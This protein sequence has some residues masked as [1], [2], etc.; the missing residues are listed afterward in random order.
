MCGITGII[1]KEKITPAESAVAGRMNKAL[2]HRG[3]NSEGHFSD[4][5][6]EMHMR[7]LSIIDL[8]GGSQ[9][10]YNENGSIVLIANG[11]I[12]N[13][14]E[15]RT[16]LESLG[17]QFKTQSDCET[18]IH[19][20]EEFGQDFL[21]HLRGMFA[22]CLYDKNLQKV[23]LARDRVGEKPLYLFEKQGKIF[24][25]SEMKSLLEA[26]PKSERT[27]DPQNI[28]E[29]FLYQYIPEPKTVFKEI[30]KLPAGHLI[31]IDLNTFSKQSRS[32]WTPEVSNREI[33]ED[34]A[35]SIRSELEEIERIVIRSDVP[36]GVSLSGG[37]DSSIVATLAA[38]NSTH[39]LHAFSV[40]YPG[41]PANDERRA[42]E[43]LAKKLNMKFHNIEINGDEFLNDFETLVHDMDD[44]VADIAAYGY[45]RVAQ[46]AR[47][48]S[49][50]VVLVGFGG[51]E[52]FWGYPWVARA[53]ELTH[54]KKTIGGKISVWV[55]LTKERG[56]RVLVRPG[57]MLRM[58]KLAFSN[59]TLLYA[60]TPSY[61]KTTE[62]KRKIFTRN[63]LSSVNPH[64]STAPIKSKNL[65]VDILSQLRN[66]WLVSNCL[67]LGDRLSMAHGVELRL[68]L[69][70]STLYSTVYELTNQYP[71]VHQL[72]YKH[73][74]IDATKD[75]IPKEIL[76][77]KKQ[78]FNPPTREWMATVIQKNAE[79]LLNGKLVSYDIL[80]KRYVSDALASGAQN[81]FLYTALVLEVWL[82]KF[83][84]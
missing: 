55:S 50:P 8:E 64:A 9:P 81:E 82:S 56:W 72:G 15:L 49:V 51:D 21:S 3:P 80:S 7:R 57:T 36:V 41:Y 1:S 44:P 47:E 45:Y 52:L 38:K 24:F 22:F 23:I 61:R 16:E 4:P 54:K 60:L 58:L 67:V 48:A 18:I 34:P 19:V 35:S 11:E 5:H 29:Y 68:P 43:T 13:F 31:E 63:F 84:V 32:Y 70:D 66:V 6:I 65:A 37:I 78:G 40:G 20:Y 28:F 39:Q 30:H 27:L 53:A 73:W 77:R 12:Y 59:E 33:T 69:V 2:F 10:L 42:A 74:L 26:V 14:I 62:Q 46:A 79:L 76:E 25:S 17:H 71:N 75:I 83:H